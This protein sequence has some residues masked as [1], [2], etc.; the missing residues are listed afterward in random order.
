MKSVFGKILYSTW[1]I[2]M[3]HD[4][5]RVDHIAVPFHEKLIR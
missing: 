2:Y 5:S 1:R 4:L 3:N